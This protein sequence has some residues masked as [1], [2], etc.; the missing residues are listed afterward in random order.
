[1]TT[2]NKQAAINYLDNL[3]NGTSDFYTEEEV[4]IPP[5]VLGYDASN[6]TYSLTWDDDD[7]KQIVF[8]ED[9]EAYFDLERIWKRHKPL[10]ER[11]KTTTHEHIHS[12]TTCNRLHR[13]GCITVNEMT[14]PFTTVFFGN[15]KN[16][17]YNTGCARTYEDF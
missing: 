11:I 1:M 15:Y 7:R 9:T 2:I 14:T 12:H 16:D 4:F 17:M 13:L 6:D 8:S 3:A 10:F 5:P